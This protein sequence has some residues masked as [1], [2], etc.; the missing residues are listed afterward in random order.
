VDDSSF[1]S[2]VSIV[3]LLFLNQLTNEIIYLH[4]WCKQ[5]EDLDDY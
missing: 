1:E 4:E 2:F 3:L 5:G